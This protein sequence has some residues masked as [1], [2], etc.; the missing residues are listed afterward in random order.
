[1]TVSTEDSVCNVCDGLR[2][3]LSECSTVLHEDETVIHNA[4]S[5]LHNLKCLQLH[6]VMFGVRSTQRVV[7]R[8]R[9]GDKSNVNMIS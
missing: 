3:T 8:V 7:L 5:I 9:V 4:I 2:R 6:Y 1:M